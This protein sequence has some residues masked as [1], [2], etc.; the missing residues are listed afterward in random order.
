M[1]ASDDPRYAS[2]ADAVVAAAARNDESRE[3]ACTTACIQPHTSV[4]PMLASIAR[5]DALPLA[6]LL[7]KIRDTGD[8]DDNVHTR[9]ALRFGGEDLH[10]ELTATRDEDAEGWMPCIRLKKV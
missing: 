1:S 7:Q 10:W 8:F 5:R 9:G 3:K 6:W 2:Y 4:L